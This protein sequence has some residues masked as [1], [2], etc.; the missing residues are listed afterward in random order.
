MTSFNAILELIK[1]E[2]K[3]EWRMKYAIAGAILYVVTTVF[4]LYTSIQNEESTPWNALYWMLAL[5]IAVNAITKSFALNK[6]GAHLYLYQLASPIQIIIAKTI[7][8]LCLVFLL[9]LVS[10]GVFSLFLGNPIEQIGLFIITLFL[11]SMGLSLV[12]TFVSA[13]SSKTANSGVF[14]AILG[15]PLIIPIFLSLIK[16]TTI[17]LQSEAGEYLSDISVLI[18]IDVILFGFVIILFPYLWRD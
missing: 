5:F 12:L 9:L 8:N 10:F 18:A 17:T 7:Y 15:F 3:M 14:M 4:V 6:S 11:G 13:I 2:L 16:L 1:L